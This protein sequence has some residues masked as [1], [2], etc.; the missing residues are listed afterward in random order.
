MRHQKIEEYELSFKTTGLGGAYKHEPFEIEIPDEDLTLSGYVT[1]P[2]SRTGYYY[3]GKYQKEKICLHFTAGHLRGDAATLTGSTGK[4]I[5]VPFLIARDG[6]IYQ[7]HSSAHWAHHLG[8]RR[9][10]NRTQNRKTIG[11]ELSNYGYLIPKADGYLHSIYSKAGREDIYCSLD[12]TH[13][14]TR[15]DQP[16]RGQQYFAT[17]TDEQYESLILL[18]RYLTTSYE[19]PREFL[20]KSIRHEYTEAVFDFKGIC[21]HVNFRGKNRHGHYEKWDIGPAFDWERVIFGVQSEVYKPTTQAE[22][23]TLTA[24]RELEEATRRLQAAQLNV[25]QAQQALA[26]AEQALQAE[27]NATA[28]TEHENEEVLIPR[29]VEDATRPTAVGSI[30]DPDSYGIEEPDEVEDVTEIVYDE[31]AL[32]PED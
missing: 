28:D 6:T 15:L 10:D 30:G 29:S 20:E 7:L 4:R 8:L 17:Y 3:T 24:R 22:R 12:D 27:R 19:I 31:E 18:L 32:F 9:S 11:I 5:S 26:E 14:Y 1:R 2:K 23:A 21:S 16:Y 25:A 13:L